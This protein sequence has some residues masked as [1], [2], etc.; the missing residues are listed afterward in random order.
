MPKMIFVNL[1]VAD[2]AKSTAFYEALG[3]K[4]DVRFC[5]ESTSM[6]TFSDTI[7]FMLLSHQRFRDF[8]SKPIVDAKVSVEA[9]L[10]LTEDSRAGV[11]AFVEKGIAAGGKGD[12]CPKQDYGF[13]YG[14]SFEDLD[15]HI[16]EV[17]WMDVEAAMAAST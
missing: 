1:P 15:G 10:C 4:R 17:A 7:H 6:M 2:V 8:T 11:D 3:A 13:M 16:I 9:L 12:P 14:R 5:N